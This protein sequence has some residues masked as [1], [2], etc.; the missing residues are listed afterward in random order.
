MHIFRQLIFQR[1]ISLAFLFAVLLSQTQLLYA[2]EQM[3]GKPKMVCCC[4]EHMS[5]TCPMAT[6]C[7]MHEQDQQSK[8]CEVSY[9]SLSDV[10]MSQGTSTADYL[11]LLL[12]GPQPPPL[13]S[14]QT[15][16]LASLKAS[17]KLVFPP[18]KSLSLNRG[19]QTY[20]LTRRLRL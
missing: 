1:T 10:S 11:T 20:L 5:D 16:S 6:P 12:D 8:C 15:L 2:C 18:D 3:D 19:N 9:D 14:E 7:S 4:D 17:H 13:I